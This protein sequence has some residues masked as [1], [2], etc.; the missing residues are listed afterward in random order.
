LNNNQLRILK[1]AGNKVQFLASTVDDMDMCERL[2]KIAKE[3]G[4]ITE[5]EL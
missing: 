1:S 3:I 4:T 5:G 2:M